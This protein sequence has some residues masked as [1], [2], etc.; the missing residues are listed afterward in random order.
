MPDGT[1][2]RRR[3]LPDERKRAG[4]AQEAVAAV[5]R[6]RY[7]SATLAENLAFRLA[8]AADTPVHELLSDASFRSSG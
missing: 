5:G 8:R 3:W 2:I 6:G 7:V 1:Q 4:R